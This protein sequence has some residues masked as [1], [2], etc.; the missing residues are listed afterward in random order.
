MT[1]DAYATMT[2]LIEACQVTMYTSTRVEY[3]CID[4]MLVPTASQQ[5]D[6]Y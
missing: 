5:N 3:L 2:E 4:R 6:I 1:K